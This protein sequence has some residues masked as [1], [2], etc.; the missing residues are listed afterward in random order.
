MI[1][2]ACGGSNTTDSS[3]PRDN[4]ETNTTLPLDNNE[5]NN[6]LPPVVDNNETNQTIPF[7][8]NAKIFIIGDSTAAIEE[9]TKVGWATVFSEDMENPANLFNVAVGG[10]SSRS[11]K[12]TDTI[13][14]NKTKQLILNT[15]ISDGGYL[16]IAFGMNDIASSVADGMDANTKSTLPG[17]NNAYYNELKVYV[18]W[19]KDHG[20]TPVLITPLEALVK[21]SVD[22]DM[23]SYF[24]RDYGDYAQTV[25]ELAADENV[26]MLDLEQKSYSIFN[27]YDPIALVEDFSGGMDEDNNISD[28]VHFNR[29]GAKSVVS[30]IKELACAS[31]DER[32]C[33]QFR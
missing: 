16:L 12:W 9:G 31:S 7:S 2:T 32:L 21:Y 24:Q 28:R 22:S 30:W 27:A 19:S 23:H 33:A 14:W 25:R 8:T 15:D 26:S 18:D 11:Y 5:S 3:K 6:T 10:A 17:R 4:N 13:D 1:F 29:Y 20:V